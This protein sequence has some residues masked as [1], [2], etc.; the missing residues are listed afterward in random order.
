MP[1]FDYMFTLD[2]VYGGFTVK[3]VTTY[4]KGSVLS[5]QSKIVFVDNFDTLEEAYKEY[6]D[7]ELTHPLF[8]PIN[9]FD[10]LKNDG[11]Y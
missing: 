11:D 5:G 10:H 7:A 3:G 2:G 4:E 1:D 8:T 6:P 9:T